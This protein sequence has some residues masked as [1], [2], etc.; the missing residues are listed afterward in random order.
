MT[1][2]SSA[3]RIFDYCL[4]FSFLTKIPYIPADYTPYELILMDRIVRTDTLQMTEVFTENK[5]RAR[6]E[7]K[8]IEYSV[9]AIINN[10]ATY[11]AGFFYLGLVTLLVLESFR[12]L[13]SP[14]SRLGVISRSIVT[15]I[16]TWSLPSTFFYSALSTFFYSFT[17]TYSGW[18]KVYYYSMGLHI[19]LLS[20]AFSN[21][22]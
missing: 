16:L 5:V 15:L 1:G 21:W 19:W 2:G 18:R 13:V 22:L 20:D 11:F 3:G 14:V 7:K 8:F 9:P 6:L 12:C 10:N 17:E 4:Y